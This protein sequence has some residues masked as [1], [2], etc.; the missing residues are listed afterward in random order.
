MSHLSKSDNHAAGMKSSSRPAAYNCN[1]KWQLPVHFKACLNFGQSLL[2]L[3]T[4]R[5]R[6]VTTLG[7]G[8]N[9]VVQVSGGALTRIS[10]VARQSKDKQREIGSAQFFEQ[11]EGPALFF[12]AVESKRDRYSGKPISFDSRSML[13]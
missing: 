5:N 13:K 12:S 2:Q 10:G 6:S 1:L 9:L 11:G 4:R 7:S 8:A 3:M